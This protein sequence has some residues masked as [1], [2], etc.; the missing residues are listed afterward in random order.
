MRV[1]EPQP[2]LRPL[3]TLVRL[4]ASEP[5]VVMSLR[6]ANDASGFGLG[7]RTPLCLDD[8]VLS[9][10]PGWYWID[11]ARGVQDAVTV[12]RALL[13]QHE[14]MDVVT[15]YESAAFVRGVGK[16]VGVTALVIGILQ[17]GAGVVM[18]DAANN[19]STQS[20]AYTMMGTGIATLV[21][22]GVTGMLLALDS[23][24]AS[25]VLLQRGR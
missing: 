21:G 4:H 14:P 24:E 10:E 22:G 17:I 5:G 19:D 9:L 6:S 13:V 20:A 1:P 7:P 18:A 8:C 23:D 3:R 16:V 2:A 15:R 25:A 12:D 11:A